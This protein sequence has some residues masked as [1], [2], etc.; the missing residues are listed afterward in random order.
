[1][2]QW[3]PTLPEGLEHI[4]L[5]C[6]QAEPENRY[7]TSEEL[8]YDLQNINK[9]TAGYRKKM[10]KRLYTF[11]IPTVLCLGFTTTS[12]FGYQGIKNEQFQDYMGLVNESSI[13]LIEGNDT[14]A[15]KLLEKAIS[16]D[17]SRASAYINLLEVYI[18]RNE[19]D[20]G[21][22]K[23]ESY[24]NDKYGNIHKNSEVLFKLG[25]TYFDLKRDYPVALKYF[26]QVDE[27]K[28][29]DASYYITLATTLG[30][31]NIDY[32]EFSTNL[33]EFESFNDNLPN[34]AKK[35]DNYNSLANI[36]ISYKGQIADANTK[37]ITVVQKAQEVL[38]F[39]SD[40]QIRLK[41]ELE[42]EQKL[43]QAFYSRGV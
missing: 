21:L 18:N 25:M 32:D 23:I 43:A 34:N 13:S 16:I 6:T 38:G 20:T 9:L 30:G 24:V 11:L 26:K 40:E 39:A 15:I 19:V 31:M 14:E 8:L 27:K 3:D 35:V 42:F 4:I 36:Y 22:S 1:I 7:Q 12:V 33:L 28:I 41:Y 2:R 37:A 17:K 29:P 5:K 10:M